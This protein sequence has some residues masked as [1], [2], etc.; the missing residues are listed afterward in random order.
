MEKI[1]LLSTSPTPFLSYFPNG[2]VLGLINH[3]PTGLETIYDYYH[4]F[5]TSHL[6]LH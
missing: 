2:P 4:A 1:S 5:T 3:Q 6:I